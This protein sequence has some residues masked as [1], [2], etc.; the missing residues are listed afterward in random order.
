MSDQPLSDPDQSGPDQSDPGQASFG[1]SE[2]DLEWSR[3]AGVDQKP[4]EVGLDERWLFS[5]E[6]RFFLSADLPADPLQATTLLRRTLSL[7]QAHLILEQTELR[8]RAAIKFSQAKKMF[9]TRQAL[10]QA[11]AEP[12]ARYKASSFPSGVALA[13]L[14]CGLGGDLIALAAQAAPG[15]ILGVEQSEVLASLA[16]ANLRAYHPSLQAQITIADACRFETSTVQAWHIDP[17]RRQSHSPPEKSSSTKRHPPTRTIN[18][19]KM[20]PSREAIDALLRRNP[21]A[22]IKLAPASEVLP[23]WAEASTR[24]WISH[25][26]EC[27]QQVLWHGPLAQGPHRHQAT[28]LDTPDGQPESLEGPPHRLP[29]PVASSIGRYVAEPDP[30]VLAAG[31]TGILATRHQMAAWSANAAYLTGDRVGESFL[32]SLFEVQEVLPYDFRRL[33]NHLHA[34]GIGQVEIKRRAVELNPLELQRRLQSKAPGQATVLI[35]PH[36]RRVIAVIARRI[37]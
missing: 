33:K 19:E 9:L 11:T 10:E 1:A 31:L 16:A 6:A 8:Q 14:C 15:A 5:A 36:N 17:D 4:V 30:A 18:P 7:K 3:Q 32:L 23:A 20:A 27:R 28:T 22:A 26:G 24:E 2:A 21:A 13:D 37:K 12:I 35:A 34:Q 25:R 29:P